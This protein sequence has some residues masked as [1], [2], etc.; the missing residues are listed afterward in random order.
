[1]Y[2]RLFIRLKGKKIGLLV[3][4][5][6]TILLLSAC[7]KPYVGRTVSYSAPFWCMCY[8]LPKTCIQNTDFFIFDFKISQGSI[9]GEYI[10]EGG[11]TYKGKGGFSKL[12]TGGKFGGSSFALVLA[13]DGIVIDY[14]LLNLMGTDLDRKL[15]F[16]TRFKSLPFDAVG[17]DYKVTVYDWEDSALQRYLFQEVFDCCVS[18]M[19]ST[20]KKWYSGCGSSTGYDQ[21]GYAI[22]Q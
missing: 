19:G 17:I 22:G 20:Y 13:K 6:G 1:M 4:L 2:S 15:P 8:N 5:V 16:K 7:T 11:A 14:L 3:F 12:A 9:S 21:I 10:I 18:K